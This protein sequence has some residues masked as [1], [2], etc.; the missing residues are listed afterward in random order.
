M[1]V[2]GRLVGPLTN[3]PFIINSLIEGYISLGRYDT[4]IYGTSSVEASLTTSTCSTTESQSDVDDDKLIF[5]ERAMFSWLPPAGD[6]SVR[7]TV[8]LQEE[9][10][11]IGM[12]DSGTTTSLGHSPCISNDWNSRR[13]NGFC[14]RVSSLSAV[15]GEC[16]VVMGSPGSG[17]SS[18][19]LALLG[20]MKQVLGTAKIQSSRQSGFKIVGYASQIPWYR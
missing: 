14:L 13:S 5:V 1:Q 8:P 7:K 15:A 16:I 11:Y 18:L 10:Y 2:V 3:F 6:G 17:K 19:L 20:E 4:F 9:E 12:A